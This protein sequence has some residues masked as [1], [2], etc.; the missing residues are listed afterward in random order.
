M[1][2]RSLAFRLAAVPLCLTCS[3][4]RTAYAG[5]D[6]RLL[7]PAAI[8][9]ELTT[10]PMTRPQAAPT[11]REGMKMPADL[12]THALLRIRPSDEE[13]H[14]WWWAAGADSPVLCGQLPHAPR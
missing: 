11:A 10:M 2:C 12:S 7:T 4:G 6:T 3:K 5:R 9:K 1:D 13:V 14:W 8:S